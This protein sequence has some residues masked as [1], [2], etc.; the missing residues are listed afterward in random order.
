[1][2]KLLGSIRKETY[3]NTYC[4]GQASV[5]TKEEFAEILQD[6]F[7]NAPLDEDFVAA[8]HHLE[9]GKQAAESQYQELREKRRAEEERILAEKARLENDVKLLKSQQEEAY[10][11]FRNQQEGARKIGGNEMA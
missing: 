2:E 5:E 10:Q 9:E 6:F 8:Y 1:M 11:T 3:E 4:I 7:V